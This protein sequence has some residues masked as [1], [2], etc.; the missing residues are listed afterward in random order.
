[1]KTQLSKA[2]RY[3]LEKSTN[4]SRLPLKNSSDSKY[5]TP[6]FRTISEEIFSIFNTHC[7]FFQLCP[8]AR[9]RI[10]ALHLCLPQG[11]Q[12]L[13]CFEWLKHGSIALKW[14]SYMN[15]VFLNFQKIMVLLLPNVSI[16]TVKF[17]PEETPEK[18]TLPNR[19]L[20]DY[21]F[22]DNII[23][24]RS[25]RPMLISW[26]VSLKSLPGYP[27]IVAS[28]MEKYNYT[29]SHWFSWIH[30]SF[31]MSCR[32]TVTVCSSWFI[33]FC[34]KSTGKITNTLKP[35]CRR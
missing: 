25:T 34:M 9:T 32:L 35:S 13:V 6:H 3:I 28:P 5:W 1:M 4:D 8:L 15:W 26:R 24:C 31:R 19:T 30:H 12:P 16:I 20:W 21:F 29:T 33:L 7:S 2:K 17:V 18:A 14:Q 23:L 11:A 27:Y 10:T 22:Q